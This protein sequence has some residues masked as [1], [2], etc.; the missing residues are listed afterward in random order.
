ML[1]LLVS[2]VLIDAANALQQHAQFV[3]LD[4]PLDQ[5]ATH[6]TPVQ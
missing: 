1:T 2:I 5:T 6:V 3:K 4:L